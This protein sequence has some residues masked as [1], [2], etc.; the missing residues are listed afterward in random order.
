MQIR[1]RRRRCHRTEPRR[2]H[3]VHSALE[4]C[5]Y[6]P[7]E[8]PI[9]LGLVA[10]AALQVLRARRPP[11]RVTELVPCPA[12]QNSLVPAVLPADV[13]G[14]APIC[15]LRTIGIQSRRCAAASVLR[16]RVRASH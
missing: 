6:E 9:A 11:Q 7:R 15:A 12:A 13:S 1:A 5:P 14:A 2:L 16:V 4:A 8:I 3:I 10:L